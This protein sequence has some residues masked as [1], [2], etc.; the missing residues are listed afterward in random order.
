MHVNT[1]TY[2]ILLLV[3]EANIQSVHYHHHHEE[4]EQE[5]YHHLF[6]CSL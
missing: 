3:Q 1:D 2:L 5:V 6:Y 4:N